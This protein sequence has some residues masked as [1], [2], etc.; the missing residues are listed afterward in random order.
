MDEGKL[1][2]FSLFAIVESLTYFRVC[3]GTPINKILKTRITCK[4]WNISLLVTST[5]KQLLQKLK[6]NKFN[7]SV[8]LAFVEWYLLH[9]EFG[10]SAKKTRISKTCHPIL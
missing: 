10:H 7:A 3:H 4:K 2:I 9:S 6:S 8:V 1:V 5:S